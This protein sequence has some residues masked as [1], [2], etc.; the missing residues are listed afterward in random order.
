MGRNGERHHAGLPGLRLM[1]KKLTNRCLEYL[2]GMLGKMKLRINEEKTRIVNA[3]EEAFNF[4][5]FTFRY[6]KDL[7]GRNKKYWNVIPS[8]KAEKKVRENIKAYLKNYG[9]HDPKTVAY[10]LNY[11]IRGWINYFDIPGINY[12]GKAKRKLRW[13]LVEKLY[14]YYRRKSQRKC[15]LHR[16]GAFEVLVSKY[17]L[18]NPC[19]MQTAR[20][21]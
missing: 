10:R 18:I 19:K 4:L 11:I 3:E 14:R 7:L 2:K 17:G 20:H 15:K 8:K 16:K 9:H 5:G 1:A 12:P 13:Y 21:L 6:D